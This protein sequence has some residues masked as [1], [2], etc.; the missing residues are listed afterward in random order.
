MR[1]IQVYSEKLGTM[2]NVSENDSDKEVQVVMEDTKSSLSGWVH[3]G[4][5]NDN[6]TVW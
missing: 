1:E 4:W 5:N 2:V 6:G 3:G